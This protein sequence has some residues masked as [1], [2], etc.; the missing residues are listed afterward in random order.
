MSAMTLENSMLR[1][2]VEVVVRE[3]DPEKIILFGFHARGSAKVGSDVDL[4]IV[5]REPFSP[6]RSRR[7][8]TFRLGMALARFP[9]AKDLLLYS[10]DEYERWKTSENHVIGKASR[11]GKL[12]HGR[13]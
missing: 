2:M 11:E 12:L 6:Q 3:A 7:K 5:E 4:I 1:E 10:R 13:F 9:F 8:E